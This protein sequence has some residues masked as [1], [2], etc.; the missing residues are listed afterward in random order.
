[1]AANGGSDL[2]YIPGKDSALARRVVEILLQQ[3]Y[4]SGLFVD[5]ALGAI[6]GTLPLKAINLEGSALT[7]VPAIAVNFTTSTTGCADPT[8]C[9]VEIADTVLQTGQ[10]MHGSFS[11]ADTRN[12]MAAAGPGFK[13][14]FSDPAP[15]SNADLGK[16][17]AALLDGRV[18]K[19]VM[20]GGLVPATEIRRQVSEPDTGGIQTILDYQFVGGTAYF[21]AAGFKGRTLGLRD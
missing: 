19:E 6:P 5:S 15:A 10:G 20:P 8:L 14:G 9:G 18:L 12:F 21:D 4:V 16:T 2:V 7:P 11:R 1:M 17:I 13:K 3:D